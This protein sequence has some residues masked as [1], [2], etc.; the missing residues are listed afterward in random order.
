MNETSIALKAIELYAASH[1][2][3]AHITQGQAAEMAGVSQPTVRKLIRSGAIK[4]NKFGL[5]PIAEFD[6]VLAA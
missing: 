4:L 5:I 3:P 6:R 1:P 2:R